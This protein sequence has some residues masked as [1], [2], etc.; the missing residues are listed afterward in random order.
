MI[1]IHAHLFE[2]LP[3]PDVE[4]DLEYSYFFDPGRISG[5]PGDC[6]PPD[7]ECEIK[8]PDGWEKR[9]MLAYIRAAQ[10]SIKEIEARVQLM[11]S[12]KKPAE[13][14]EESI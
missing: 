1:G 7:E 4:L 14:A 2:E 12:D 9:V 13:W 5:P 11:A 8:M 10:E 6:Y 3:S